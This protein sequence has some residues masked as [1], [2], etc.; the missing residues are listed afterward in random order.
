MS[1][2][3]LFELEMLE[4]RRFLTTASVDGTN[5]LQVIGTSGADDITV[6]KNSSG[7]LSVT[8]VTATFTI[9]SAAGQVNKIVI[10]AGGGNDTVLVTSNVK[11]SSGVGIPVTLAGNAGN[12]TITSGPGND[13][14]S[15]NDGDDLMDG[16]VGND[17]MTGGTGFDT[18]NYSNRTG[19]LRITMSN[20]ANDGEVAIGEADDVQTEEVLCGSG[21]DTVTGSALDDYVSGGG[22][23]DSISLGDGNDQLIGS[24]GADQLFGQN[25][26]D[27]LL[28]QNQDKDTVNG[29]TNSDGTADLDLASI[30]SVDVG[31]IVAQLNANVTNF[32]AVSNPADLDATY[33]TGGKVVSPFLGWSVQ[34]AAVDS[35]GRTVFVGTAY[36]QNSG[37]GYGNDFAA[38][39]YDA[40]GNLDTTFGSGGFDYIDLTDVAGSGYGYN[41]DDE[42]FGVAIGAGDSVFIVGDTTDAFYSSSD[43]AVVKLTS[44]GVPDSSFGNAGRVIVDTSG[45]G[46]ADSA[47]DAVV[48]ADG[49]IVVVGE[50]GSE[51]GSGRA[52]RLLGD[53]LVD[54][55]T[56]DSVPGAAFSSDGIVEFSFNNSFDSVK[57]VALQ[58]LAGDSGAQRIVVGGTSNGQFALIRF[59]SDGSLDST[60]GTNGVT[61]ENFFGESYSSTLNDIAVDASN[62]IV[63]AGS[64]TNQTITLVADGPQTLSNGATKAVLAKYS[65]AGAPLNS[66]SHDSPGSY[67]TFNSVAVDSAG[68]YVAVGDDGSDFLVMR[69]TAAMSADGTFGSSGATTTD[70]GPG[71]FDSAF[72]VRVLSTG[73]IVAAGGTLQVEASSSQA[74]IARYIGGTVN[75][76][77]PNGEADVT[78]VEDFVDYG[79]IHSVPPDPLFAPYL[80]NSS[81]TARLNTLSQPDGD[82]IAR[83]VLGDGKDV[84]TFANVIAGD[85][86][87]NVAVNVNG[88]ILYYDATTTKR[89]EVYGNGGNDC[90]TADN[91][92]TIPFLIDGGNGN[93]II[94]GGGAN[95]LLFG[96]AGIDLMNGNAGTDV[97]SGGA[98]S[99][100]LY[101]DGGRDILIGGTGADLLIGGADE[102]IQ[103]GGTTAYDTNIPALQSLAAEWGSAGANA[104]R[105]SHIR[106]TTLGGLNGTNFLK[107]GS[108]ATVFDDNVVDVLTNDAGRDWFFFRNTGAAPYKDL[109]LGGTVGEEVS[110]L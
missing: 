47:H 53:G 38:V 49:K 30:D 18:S 22:G 36:R 85:G 23:N 52:L 21:N 95:D 61:L 16:G 86:K 57:S 15:G 8:G 3:N 13:V 37:G 76:T 74:A 101:G 11:N 5:T 25:G 81:S 51:G 104:L 75:T 68:R 67:A 66:T 70:F 1:D 60:F 46:F 29:G 94:A 89:I 44:S 41:D 65:S 20:G 77:P 109:V 12:D 9:G 45:D 31:S 84:V 107:T 106:G 108:G 42:A 105:V 69:I 79:G 98:D 17:L 71:N 33:G 88:V 83:I 93:D 2:S 92:I 56:N 80:L 26:N 32:S 50:A 96:G 100:L 72:A 48:Q 73:R 78:E 34:A 62:N 103:I 10:Q 63:A 6:N 82:G 19:A 102:D 59:T 91:S 43:M 4:V 64:T 14:L 35:Q 97:L 54:N 58:T 39:R 24:S 90:I 40:D 28:A 99:D 27:A 7:K 55:T 110:L 87:V